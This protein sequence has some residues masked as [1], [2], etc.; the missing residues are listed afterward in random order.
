MFMS[1]LPAYFGHIGYSDSGH[2]R[3]DTSAVSATI[4]ASGA[5]PCSPRFYSAVTASQAALK[6]VL[7]AWL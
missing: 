5:T 4:R 3:L 2:V 7:E 1:P 6:T